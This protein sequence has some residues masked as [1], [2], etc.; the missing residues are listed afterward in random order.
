[1]MLPKLLDGT[2]F[3]SRNL[4]NL[5]RLI[6]FYGRV[7]CHVG[8]HLVACGEF[9]LWAADEA[10]G[11]GDEIFKTNETTP[12]R[13]R[14]LYETGGRV[15]EKAMLSLSHFFCQEVEGLR[16]G[17]DGDSLL[18]AGKGTQMRLKKRSNFRRL[19]EARELLYET[20]SIRENRKLSFH[21]SILPGR[22]L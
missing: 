2:S 6:H 9:G 16:G 8:L 7:R 12:V 3:A 15:Y 13:R 14:S 10:G 18:F 1:M 21:P 5:N 22:Y 19:Y 17:F 11:H 20:D 4:R